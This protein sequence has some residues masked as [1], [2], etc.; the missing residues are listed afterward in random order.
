MNAIYF[1]R[2]FGNT[3]IMNEWR[4]MIYPNVDPNKYWISE[5]GDIYNSCTGHFIRCSRDKDGYFYFTSKNRNGKSTLI[6]INRAVFNTFK[7]PIEN[8]EN[9]QI[10]HINDYPI[11]PAFG[12]N[13][14]NNHYTNLEAVS[15][16][17]NQQ[18]ATKNGYRDSTHGE[19]C[20]FA[21]ITKE[22]ARLIGQLI[23]DNQHTVSEIVQLTGAT[24]KI[25]HDIYSGKTWQYEFTEDEKERIEE[26]R[27][28]H[29]TFRRNGKTYY[30]HY[31]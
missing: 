1:E 24:T 4:P 21:S 20:N 13:K 15:P 14:M 22:T 16:L 12:A 23:M 25:V 3:F 18:H 9:L 11:L 27:K 31:K 28:Y 2:T 26:C 29:P 5:F 19:N 17:E 30:R 6:R 8:F 7:G 10:N